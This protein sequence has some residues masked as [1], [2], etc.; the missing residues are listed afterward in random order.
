MATE[1]A[2]REQRAEQSLWSVRGA[3]HA[4]HCV[5][6]GNRQDNTTSPVENRLVM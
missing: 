3:S 6:A 5:A 4:G 1:D 2:R